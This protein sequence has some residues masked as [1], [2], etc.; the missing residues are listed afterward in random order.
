MN[1]SMH[2]SAYKMEIEACKFETFETVQ[3]RYVEQSL[4]D[5]FVIKCKNI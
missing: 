5:F 2:F 4:V 1:F 3:N